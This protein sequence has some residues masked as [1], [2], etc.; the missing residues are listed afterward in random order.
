MLLYLLGG[1]DW[2]FNK[3]NNY[4]YVCKYYLFVDLRKIRVFQKKHASPEAIVWV[5]KKVD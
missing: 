5:L 3:N 1:L 2:S 4:I